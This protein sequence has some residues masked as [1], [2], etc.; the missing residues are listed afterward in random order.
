MRSAARMKGG[1]ARPLAWLGSGLALAAVCLAAGAAPAAADPGP[2]HINHLFVIVLENENAE[3]TFGA[4]PPAPYLGTTMRNAGAFIPNYNGIGH[5]SL[6]NYLALVSGQP[7]NLATQADCLLYTEMTPLMTNSDGVAVGQG[8]VFPRSVQTVANQLE[9]SG[10][11]WRG[12]MQDMANSV[13]AGEPAT[14]RHPTLNGQ[15]TTQSARPTDQYA[16]RHDPFVYFHS[17]IDYATCQR[18]VV[19]LANLPEDLKKE[20]T[21][22]EY[23]FIT[24]DLCADGHDATCADPTAPGGFAGIN[25]F[26]S[27]WVPLIEASPAY[28]DHGAILV[29]FDE[30]ESGAESCCNEPIG[31]NTFNNG[32]P[33][34]GNGGGKVGAVVV[35]PCVRPGTVT[36]VPYNHYSTLRWTEDNFG[37]AHLA[38]AGTEGLAPFGTD[39]FSKPSCETAEEEAQARANAKTRLQVRPRRTPQ[40]R[41]R[42]FRFRLVSDVP[43]CSVGAAVRFAGHRAKSNRSGR[44]HLKARPRRAG[45]LVAVARPAGCPLA[46]ARVRVLSRRGG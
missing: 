22:P 28:R 38:D 29:T 31:P 21:T 1:P 30:S 18:N 36:Q 25:A 15:D 3:N 23:D 19:D 13:S 27:H 44:A 2:P 33:Q 20:A 7:P 17:I 34:P 4:V 9:N 11:S 16:A 32:G 46:K 42:V 6:D 43:A 37:L 24:P 14:C 10:H 45:R 41:Q 35:S 12:Y 39:V 26:L 40:G 5:Q 8:C